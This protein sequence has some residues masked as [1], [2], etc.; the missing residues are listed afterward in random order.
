MLGRA[1]FSAGVFFSLFK[2][3]F[4]ISVDKK[5]YL[6]LSSLLKHTFIFS[7]SVY[8]LS[9]NGRNVACTVQ[10]VDENKN[11]A[12]DDLILPCSF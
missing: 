10:F 8:F 4:K 3:C 1:V 5:F 6:S 9:S 12:E 2:C 7:Y 11:G